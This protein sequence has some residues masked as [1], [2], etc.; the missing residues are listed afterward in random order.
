M[1]YYVQFDRQGPA[2]AES[3]PEAQKKASE[4]L[5]AAVK[6]ASDLPD[7]VEALIT[8]GFKIIVSRR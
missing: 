5:I 6:K 4:E 3:A 2:E 7:P 8:V 1:G